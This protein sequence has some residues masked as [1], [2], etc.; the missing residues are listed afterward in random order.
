M[1]FSI[2][3]IFKK[4]RFKNTDF[5]IFHKFSTYWLS[6]QLIQ[7]VLYIFSDIIIIP[8]GYFCHFIMYEIK[9]LFTPDLDASS[10]RVIPFTL[11]AL[12]TSV[13]C[14]QLYLTA[15]MFFNTRSSD[16]TCNYPDSWT[17][18]DIARV[19]CIENIYSVEN[20][21]FALWRKCVEDNIA[22]KNPPCGHHKK[23]NFG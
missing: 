22:E 15:F 12:C 17:N 8:S 21:S 14:L 20:N 7:K 2:G 16:L 18:Q 13:Y 19:S 6:S 10:I 3:V 23:T 11:R 1:N 5:G 9:F 4:R